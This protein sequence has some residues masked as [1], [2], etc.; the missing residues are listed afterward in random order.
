[1]VF[2]STAWPKIGEYKPNF[3]IQ[4]SLSIP[5]LPYKI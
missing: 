2:S 5:D 1:M 3:M 4:K